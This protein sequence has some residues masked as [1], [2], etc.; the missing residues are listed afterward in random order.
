[1][2]DSLD[3]VLLLLNEFLQ[4]FFQKILIEDFGG[5]GFLDFG[6]IGDCGFLVCFLICFFGFV[7]VYSFVLICCYFK[8]WLLE[9]VFFWCYY[10]GFVC[11]GEMM[12]SGLGLKMQYG[13][14]DICLI[15]SWFV[16]E[17]ECRES[18]EVLFFVVL[19]WWV[20]KE[21]IGGLKMNKVYFKVLVQFFSCKVLMQLMLDL[22]D[23]LLEDDVVMQGVIMIVYLLWVL[24]GIFYDDDE[25][26]VL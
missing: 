5:V 13:S 1:M 23:Q 14:G 19:V 8:F 25:E 7:Q 26:I 20:I 18:F 9:D 10:I 17:L 16:Y 11:V 3:V 12:V 22:C 15:L 2:C 21:V 4:Q 24:I 6:W